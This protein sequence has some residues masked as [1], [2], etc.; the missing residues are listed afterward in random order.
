MAPTIDA[1]G[2][3][4]HSITTVNRQYWFKLIKLYEIVGNLDALHG[5]WCQLAQQD[6][7]MFR[8]PDA[9]QDEGKPSR[10]GD[11]VDSQEQNVDPNAE[12][13]APRDQEQAVNLVKRAQELKNQGK[14]DKALKELEATLQHPQMRLNF[15][16]AIKRELE[17]K[18][19]EYQSELLKWD[20]ISAEL[21]EMHEG[22]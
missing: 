9:E 13:L 20:V 2:R 21:L 16:T 18:K 14:I 6:G 17:N 7:V 11:A 5:I 19:Y 15:E 10:G 8:S 1:Q 4:M 22:K 3:N 12:A